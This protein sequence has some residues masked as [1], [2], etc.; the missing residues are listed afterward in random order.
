MN[1]QVLPWA[2]KGELDNTC[3][4][5]FPWEIA[6]DSIIFKENSKADK[7]VYRYNE[8]NQYFIKIS[9]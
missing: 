9:F 7:C 1:Q 3:L 2:P 5:Y 4:S 6:G 8:L